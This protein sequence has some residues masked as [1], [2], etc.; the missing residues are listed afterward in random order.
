M[1][2]FRD[3]TTRPGSGSLRVT[4][5]IGS[6]SCGSRLELGRD[7][8]SVR[9]IGMRWQT[10]SIK[11]D[12]AIMLFC[13]VGLSFCNVLVALGFNL[14][15]G[16]QKPL[17]EPSAFFFHF[18]YLVIFLAVL[19]LLAGIVAFFFL[20]SI[21]RHIYVLVWLQLAISVY[22]WLSTLFILGKAASN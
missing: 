8:H 5:V 2:H 11:Y 10:L 21:M 15:L 7:R 6:G 19:W 9:S 20:R 12:A 1:N 18:H 13:I 3:R 16:I 22:A 4:P 17:P 14:F